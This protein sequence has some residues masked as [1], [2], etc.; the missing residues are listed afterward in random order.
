MHANHQIAINKE[1]AIP[2]LSYYKSS[3]VSLP[4]IVQPQRITVSIGKS[5][6]QEMN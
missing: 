2:P 3:K 5:Y 6:G 4:F 1:I